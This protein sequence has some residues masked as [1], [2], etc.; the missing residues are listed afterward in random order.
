MYSQPS[1]DATQSNLYG[2][3]INAK[4]NETLR[5]ICDLCGIKSQV[6]CGTVRSSYIPKMIDE[7]FHPLQVA[8]LAGNL[9]T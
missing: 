7:G 3:R 8:E 6:I 2:K 9:S 5:K 4:V 1:N